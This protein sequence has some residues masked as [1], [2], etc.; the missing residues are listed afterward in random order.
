MGK[1]DDAFS[2]IYDG[3]NVL[4]SKV[5]DMMGSAYMRVKNDSTD[6]DAKILLNDLNDIAQSILYLQMGFVENYCDKNLV[7]V[8]VGAIKDK[9]DSLSEIKQVNKKR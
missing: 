1:K 4:Y 8:L 2:S 5:E 6:E 3:M 7:S 9:V